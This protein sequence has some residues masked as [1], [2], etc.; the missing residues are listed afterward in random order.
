[1]CKF[2]IGFKPKKEK[3]QPDSNHIL[4]CKNYLNTEGTLLST[5]P[6]MTS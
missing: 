1:M 3:I 5:P 6:P 4:S 2:W